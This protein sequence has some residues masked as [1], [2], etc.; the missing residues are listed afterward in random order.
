MC[1]TKFFISFLLLV[2][3]VTCAAAAP[4]TFH[5]GIISGLGARNIGSAAMSGR[6][7]ALAG[8]R[9][10]SGKIT[11]YVGAASGGIWKSE[12]SGTLYRPVF[13]KQSVQSTGAIAID[14]SNSNNV[15]VGT[16]E[17]WTRNSVS[18]GDG[19]YKSADGGDTWVNMGLP[20]SERIAKILVSP[21]DSNTVYACV[22]GK[23]WSDSADRGLYKTTDGGKS[24]SLVLKG[25]N[26]S[27]GCSMISLDPANP[28]IIFAGMW[29]FRRQG[30]T[31]RS[32]GESPTSPS[33]SGLYRSADAGLT[34]SEITEN[35]NKGF[36]KKPFGRIAVTVAP[37]DAKRVYAFVESTDSALYVSD[38][39]GQTWQVRDKSQW[40]VWRPFYFANL[41]VD[42]LNADKVYK[43][44][45]AL[46]LSTDAGKSFSVVG[47]FTGM[48]GDVHDV[49][50]D[51]TLSTN[52]Q[53]IFA[54]DDGGMWYSYN[55]GSKWWKG[56]NLPVSQFY[57]VSVDNKDP[58]QIYGGLQDNSSWIGQSQYPGGITNSQW[59]NMYG[60]DGFWMFA[61]PSDSNYLYAEAQGGAIGRVNRLT[62]ES[63]DIQPRL[64][65]ADLKA[66]KKLRFNWNT[67]IALSPSDKNTV[68]IGS[69]F[70]YRT[71]DHG[72]SWS[73][74]SPDLTTNNP[75][76]QQQEKSGGVTVDNSA[77]EMYETIYS[78]SE[79]PKNTN[80]IWAGTDDG[81]LQ[82]TRDAGKSWSNVVA[83]VTGL[84]A[85]S[86]VSWVQ[87]SNFDAATAYAAFDRHTVG[88]MAV[89]V[90]QTRDFGKTWKPLLSPA[91]LKGVQGYA[92]VVKE[93]LVN[94]NLLFLGTE[95]GLYISIDGGEGWA[96]FKGGNLPAVA[97]RDI[98][99]HPRDNDLV[100]ATHGRGIWIVDD[101]TP[102]RALSAKLLS[103]EISFVANRGTQQRL[104]A[105]G[106]W[107]DGDAVFVG[108][109][110]P[111]GA[112]ITYY[113][114]TRHLFGKL[115]LE[116]IDANGR[117]VEQLSA[118]KRPGLNRVTWS[119]RE[120][121]PRVPP[122]A[123]LA[124]SGT[125]GPRVLPGDYRIRMTKNGQTIETKMV[126]GLDRRA[127]FTLADRKAQFGAALRVKALFDGESALM[128]RITFLRSELA[129]NLDTLPESSEL[130]KQ[131]AALDAKIDIVRKLIVATT[132]G[133]AITG[134]ER[135]REHTDQLYGAILG[136]EG[137]PADYQIANIMALESEL[138]EV[139]DQFS[140]LLS[141]DLKAL[142]KSLSGAGKKSVAVPPQII[143]WSDSD[144][145][146]ARA[147]MPVNLLL[148]R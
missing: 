141:D 115:T 57:H 107:R 113:Q 1:S 60:G 73:R 66:F 17:A 25:N 49:W 72:Q 16:G 45:G 89:Y 135:L 134:E 27:T 117:V 122:A 111:D 31:F 125:Q 71:R 144:L 145:T 53:T 37:S 82:V 68:Y 142:N 139:S 18:I 127:T 65:A 46:I 43:T 105:N 108:E 5:S 118:G 36:P 126:V 80:V 12:D 106:G 92:H 131:V 79:S 35:T 59:E 148:L 9:T 74:I 84:P 44:D 147:Q 112:A 129:Q 11:L 95:M 19:I 13:D 124:Q 119:M 128:D 88:D 93:D 102:L 7:S 28:N 130:K 77:A 104:Q 38:D 132:E 54:G 62:H 61:D 81:N 99:I 90:Y 116:V 100:L 32:G 55:G 137:K 114:R 3:S 121:P 10:A 91:N 41:I 33:G 51:P 123:Q 67:P 8:N 140:L 34:W 20:N 109:N 23:L 15:W 101:I 136:Y 98:A 29:D 97:V 39:A 110:P 133:G 146:S 143:A 138:K 76:K 56:G 26:L 103:E 2:A 86:W 69:Q 75:D 70:L 24:W 83:N 85:G 22:A 94:P 50:I 87:A 21:K 64:N 96:R 47:G 120:K 4:A 52:G 48:H 58:Y 6:I 42:P 40:M 78:I 30:W 14:P 63:R